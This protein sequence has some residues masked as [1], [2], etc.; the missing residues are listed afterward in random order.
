MHSVHRKT[1]L[2][3]AVAAVAFA[4]L[5]K[6]ADIPARAAGVAPAPIIAVPLPVPPRPFIALLL[7]LD[8][9]DFS[10]PAEAVL[11]GCKAALAVA[12]DNPSLKVVRTDASRSHIMAGYEA[13]VTRVAAVIVGAMKRR[14]VTPPGGGGKN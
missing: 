10:A 14:R 7:P 13:A 9:P 6:A 3:F 5:C 11:A 1:S 8:A 12:E 2:F 4:A